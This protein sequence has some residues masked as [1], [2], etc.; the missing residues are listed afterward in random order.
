[1]VIGWHQAGTSLVY[2][3][4][5]SPISTSRQKMEQTWCG[6]PLLWVYKIQLVHQT[7][8]EVLGNCVD[9][10]QGYKVLRAWIPFIWGSFQICN[11][12]HMFLCRAP[13]WDG[14]SY[15][16]AS[17]SKSSNTCCRMSSHLR[18]VWCWLSW[19]V[20]HCLLLCSQFL[21]A[22]LFVFTT[23]IACSPVTTRVCSAVASAACTIL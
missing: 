17:C 10:Y 7:S 3:L 18:C 14:L 6:L 23:Q 20:Q 13:I 21:K 16:E 9:G 1:M 2:P 22:P 15:S 12:H 4:S 8:F 19:C 11:L 5:L